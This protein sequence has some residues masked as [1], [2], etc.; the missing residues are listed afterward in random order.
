MENYIVQIY[1]HEKEHSRSLIGIVETVGSEEK[2]PFTNIDEL[3]GI[4][5]PRKK[6]VRRRKSM[7]K[8]SGLP[9]RGGHP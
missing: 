6:G 5:N 2:K 7:G 4:L 9:S 3:W 8:S 1:R